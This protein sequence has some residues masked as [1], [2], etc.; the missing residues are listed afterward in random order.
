MSDQSRTTTDHDEIR[1]WAE[2]RGGRPT[3]V[4]DT[5]DGDDAG[6]IRIDFPG[7]GGQDSLREISW[8]EWFD[9]FDASK[10]AIVLQDHTADGKQSNFNRLVK[11]D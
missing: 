10:L 11:R 6:I 7:Y 1:E 5:A 3:T 8:E 2:Q 4:A 9:K